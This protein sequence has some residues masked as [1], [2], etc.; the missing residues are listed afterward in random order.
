MFLN[1]TLKP[2][3]QLSHTG[4]LLGVTDA[5]MQANG[6][7]TELI[8]PVDLVLPPGVQPDMTEHGFDRDD[9]PGLCRKVMAADG[10]ITR[11]THLAG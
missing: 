9:W 1:C 11:H 6:V 3:G 8:R 4:E 2:T 7:S 5:I 10:L